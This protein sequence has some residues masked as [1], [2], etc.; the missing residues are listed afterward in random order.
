MYNPTLTET[1]QSREMLSVFGGYNHNRRIS[2]GEF[3][4]MTNL[5][6]SG[7]PLLMSRPARGKV[8]QLTAPGGMLAKDAMAVVD[9]GKLYYNGKEITGLTLS[10][11]DKQMEIGRAHV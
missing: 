9:G 10:D 1:S 5:T 11:G 4:D 2:D 3:Y 8:Q 6:S 7:Y